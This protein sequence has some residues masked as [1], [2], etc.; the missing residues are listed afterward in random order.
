[1]GVHVFDDLA[2][3][4]DVKLECAVEVHP[5]IRLFWES[6][7]VHI[8]DEFFLVTQV[9]APLVDDLHP[10]PILRQGV[11]FFIIMSI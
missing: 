5:P 6:F 7:T 1:M 3:M 4:R 9:H 8:H 2:P 10:L 11:A